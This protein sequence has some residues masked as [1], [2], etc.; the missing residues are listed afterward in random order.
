MLP[1]LADKETAMA[2]AILD[3]LMSR[4]AALVRE[5]RQ[6][7]NRFN[8]LVLQID[9]LDAVIWQF[10]PGYKPEDLPNRSLG[11]LPLTRTVPMVMRKAKAPMTVRALTLDV[12]GSL[13]LD[14]AN[15]QRVKRIQEQVRTVMSQQKRNGIVEPVRMSGE[16]RAMGWRVTLPGTC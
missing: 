5:V 8:D 9:Q 16:V 1:S 11:R 10:E 3:G 4:R 6:A 2:D 13:G 7:E 12:M 15:P 14:R